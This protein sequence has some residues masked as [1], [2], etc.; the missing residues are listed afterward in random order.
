MS[1]LLSH[2]ATAAILLVFM[3]PALKAQSQPDVSKFTLHAKLITQPNGDLRVEASSPWP[4][5]QAISALS[6]QYG[7]VI[8]YED[9]RYRDTETY[10]NADGRRQL[11]GGQFT[12]TIPQITDRNSEAAALQQLV[13]QFNAK[14]GIQFKLIQHRDGKRFDVVGETKGEKPILDTP[15]SL[16]KKSRSAQDAIREIT[17]QVG[18]LRGISILEGGIV[19]N[20]LIHTEVTVGGPG[21]KPAREF[22]TNVVNTLPAESVWG[23]GYEPSWGNFVIA[24]HS[25]RQDRRP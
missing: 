12:A 18:Q 9:P 2:R 25:V 15:I 16:E 10:I 6:F 22:L 4:L 21:R 20:A 24:I 7:L 17:R 19:N 11:I 3:C 5:Y 13:R 14:G 23:V 8:D 1:A